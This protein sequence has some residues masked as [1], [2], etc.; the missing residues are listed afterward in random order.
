MS[1]R[2]VAAVVGL[3]ERA[4]QRYTTDETNLDLL[5]GVA[6]LITLI[7][8]SAQVRQHTAALRTASRQDLSSG[9][10]AHNQK[11]LDPQI[12]EACAVGLRKYPEMPAAQKR[13]FARTMNDHALFLQTA[14]ALYQSGALGDEN[15]N[16]YLT[17]LACQLAT[18]GGSAWWEETKSF[19]NEALVESI[20]GRLA[21]GA[22][23]DPLEVGLFAFD[24]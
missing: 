11:H 24:G 12:S 22:L 4:P 5:S 16:P 20:D 19:Y 17:W 15:Y 8:L 21:A 3:A 23:P 7:Y 1:L 10:R 9:Y 14:F 2:G 6:V 13:L 18:P